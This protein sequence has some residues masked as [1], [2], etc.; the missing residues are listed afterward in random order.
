VAPHN[1]S[2]DKP[3]CHS[4]FKSA[5][6]NWHKQANFFS[7]F[8]QQA[9]YNTSVNFIHLSA[10]KWKYV[11][12]MSRESKQFLCPNTLSASCNRYS[13]GGEWC[14]RG[15]LLAAVVILVSQQVS[16][17]YLDKIMICISSSVY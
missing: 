7:Q 14:V 1:S 15:A 3:M 5:A 10:M 16:S 2:V 11:F 6:Y 4:T 17:G 8:E 12:K 13:S 9:M